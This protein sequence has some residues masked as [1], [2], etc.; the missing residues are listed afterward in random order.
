LFPVSWST[1]FVNWRSD[2]KGEAGEGAS[3][4]YMGKPNDLPRVFKAGALSQA[5]IFKVN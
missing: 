5:D 4:L 1:K 3:A 2:R